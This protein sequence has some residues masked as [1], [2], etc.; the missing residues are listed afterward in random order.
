MKIVN[1][2]HSAD[3]I[4]TKYVQETRDHLIETVV[5]DRPEKR[6]VCFST[7]VGCP[8]KCSICEVSKSKYIRNLI[9]EE[10]I[11]QCTGFIVDRPMLFSAMGVGEPSMNPNL[12]SAFEHLVKFGSVAVSTIGINPRSIKAMSYALQNVK[13]KVQ[14]LI[15]APTDGL[16]RQLLDPRLPNLKYV[17]NMLNEISHPIEYNYSLLQDVNDSESHAEALADILHETLSRGIVKLNRY[18]PI[19]SASYQ[20]S[21]IDHVC[22]FTKVLNRRGIRFETYATDGHDIQSACGQLLYRKKE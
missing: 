4:T 9:Y 6:I 17:L 15:H 10:L 1:E 7:Q 20:A 8:M 22:K 12:T 3:G 14:L 16:R 13:L 18:N 5:V 19:A 21:D 11:D 2:H